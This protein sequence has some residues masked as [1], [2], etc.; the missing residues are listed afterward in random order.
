MMRFVEKA[1]QRFGL[2]TRLAQEHKISVWFYTSEGFLERFS[3]RK[4][5]KEG[6]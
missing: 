3:L 2:L 4:Q 5:T 6:V 1:Q